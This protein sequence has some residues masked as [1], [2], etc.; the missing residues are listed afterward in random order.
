MPVIKRIITSTAGFQPVLVEFENGKI[1]PGEEKNLES[2]IYEEKNGTKIVGITTNKM[3]YTG[4]LREDDLYNNFLLIHNKKKDKIEMVQ[5]DCC[6]AT[7]KLN[8][9]SNLIQ[10]TPLLSREMNVSELQKQF[11]SKKSKRVTEQRERLTM[12]IETVKEQL[13]KTVTGIKLDES[14]TEVTENDSIYRPK[15]NRDASTR[16]GI[17]NLED[18]VPGYILDTLAPEAGQIMTTGNM[19]PYNF[20]PFV[21]NS[22]SRILMND[23]SEEIQIRRITIFLYINYLIK[24]MATPMKN[25]TKKFIVCD[26]SP[27]VNSHILDTFSVNSQNSRTRPLHMKDKAVCYT[28]VLAAIAMEYEVNVEQ[29]SKDLKIGVKK[30]L[31]VSRILAFNA[32]KDKHIVQLK[33]PLPAPVT[34]SSKRKRL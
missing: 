20:G 13:E 21:S 29:L 10:S 15:I 27:D 1:Q 7:P 31:E 30:T 11:G 25:I 24:F 4:P 8:K 12:N 23:A 26:K 32:S 33:L 18:L 16:D 28:L 19:Q 9:P 22:I 3:L 2:G 17:Y 6:I 5:I 34:F 14:A